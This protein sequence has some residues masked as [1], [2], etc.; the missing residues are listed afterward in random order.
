MSKIIQFPQLSNI[1]QSYNG[2]GWSGDP[3]SS[4]NLPLSGNL[5]N[6][7]VFVIANSGANSAILAQA[8][9]AIDYNSSV[10]GGTVVSFTGNDAMGL[11]KN[12]VLIDVFGDPS[13]N[14]TIPV[15]G[16]TSY[17]MDHTIVRKSSVTSGNTDWVSSSGTNITDSEWI[18]YAQDTWTYIGS[19]TMDG[20]SSITYASGYENLDVANVTS[21]AVIGLAAATDYYYVVRAYNA[22]GTSASSN[23]IEVTTTGG[24]QNPVITNIV[25]NPA[26]GFT[27][28]TIVSVSADVTDSDGTVEG[29]E[30]HWGTTSGSLG[31]TISMTNTSGD[32]FKTVTDIP[33]QSNGVTVYYEI[34]AIDDDADD[35][36]SP[37]QSYTVTDPVVEPTNHPTGFEAVASSSSAIIVGWN[38]AVPA[39]AGYL[40]KGST[41]SYEDI[42]PPVDGTPESDALLVQNFAADE[43][44]FE[45]TGLTASTQYFFKIYPYNGSGAEINY[46]TDGNVPETTATT[47]AAVVFD[48]VETFDNFDATGT[49]YLTGTFLGQDGST[50]TYTEARGDF[51]I[52]GKALMIGRN[53]TPQSEVYSGTIGGGIQVL[54]FDYMQAYTNDVNLSVLVNDVVV[55]N[56]TSS[57][58]EGVVK[59]SGDITVNVTGN[60]VLKFKNVNNSNGQ[61]VIDNISWNSIS[62]FS[63]YNGTGNWSETANWSKGLPTGTTDVI[64]NG[65]V[66]VDDVVECNNMTISPT[67]AV[68]V[69]AAQGLIV[70]SDLL[71]ESNASGTGSFIG[72]AADY[73]ITGTTTAQRYLSGGWS[74]WDAGW[75]QISS[76]VASQPIVDFVTAG[77]GNGYDFYGWD[78]PTNMWMNYKAAGFEAWN[79]NSANF[80]VGQGYLVSYESQNITQTFTGE[81]N[82]DDVTLEN[83]SKGGNGWHLLG[84]PYASALVWNDENNWILDNVA[85][86]A[87]IW[88]ETNK[89]YSDI[90]P[91][92][93]IP[94]AQGF[95]VQVS[96]AANGI[97]FYATARTHDTQPFYKAGNEQLLLVAAETEGGSAQES[98]IIINSMATEGFDFE[99]D[100]RFLAGYAPMLYSVVGD[101]MLSTNSL[102]ELTSGKVIPF[103]FVKNA[104]TNFTIELKESIPGTVV[105]LTDFK[106]G[107]VQNLTQN[108]VYNFT[109]AE[110]DDPARFDLKFGAV[111]IGDT[112]TVEATT[113]YSHGQSLYISSTQSADAQVSVYNVT[114]QQVY[115]NRMMLDGQKQ[116]TL[117]V[118]TG[119][120]I[121]KVSTQEGIATQKV[122]IKAN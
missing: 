64:I 121:V 14:L 84:N 67:G 114:G 79:D 90:A 13:S 108:S 70:N 22:S 33:A 54:N 36:T 15:A 115:G 7:E 72:D 95:M 53:R 1:T 61:V 106:T 83:I 63:A 6:N 122:F 17:G 39:A 65:N 97:L 48:N 52:T 37:E 104:A 109:A 101:E 2:G 88:H 28:S 30:L 23:E 110:G 11:F 27:S 3:N 43:E 31:T 100:S 32:T 80:N 29:V 10:Q 40:I 47:E 87:K 60:F 107:L 112:P 117:N 66:T 89:S 118:I 5:A 85:G 75:H 82:S 51:A 116:I 119:W 16:F 49:S 35:A 58:E 26:S 19:H 105:Y 44:I 73:V 99:Y 78:E 69:G 56:V 62:A 94:S 59:N 50:W 38:D 68:T 102:P 25:T 93:I 57:V 12:E 92:G 71:I 18:G 20:A 98:K 34:Y 81:L 42:V 4:Y 86:N 120:Y 111:G 21:Y 45:F 8:D 91:N 24:N 96:D 103:G 77:A 76:P 41:T 74:D 46:K 9:M 113:I 55:G